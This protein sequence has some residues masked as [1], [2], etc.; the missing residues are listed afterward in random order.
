MDLESDSDTDPALVREEKE[1]KKQG[2]QVKR[3]TFYKKKDNTLPE[4]F[5]DDF[6]SIT[7]G[8]EP[9]LLTSKS[10]PEPSTS[11]HSML[12]SVS[13][14]R[15]YYSSCKIVRDISISNIQEGKKIW[16]PSKK[17]RQQTYLAVLNSSEDLHAYYIVF[18]TGTQHWPGK[19]HC[20]DL[21][22]PPNS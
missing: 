2:G 22:D 10:T 18:A 21:L 12:K 7:R 8:F 4:V 11:Y 6:E 15:L 3:K 13:S 14:S 9:M 1:Q 5:S 17:A 19:I 20:N 16:K